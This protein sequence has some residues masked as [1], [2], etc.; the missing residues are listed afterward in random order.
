MEK[1]YAPII[2]NVKQLNLPLIDLPNTFDINNPALYVS[3]IEPS[4]Q[5]GEIIAR[6]ITYVMQVHKF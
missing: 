4:S 1:I 2:Q 5:G 6:L 3:Q